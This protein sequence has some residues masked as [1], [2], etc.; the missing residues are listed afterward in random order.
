MGANGTKGKTWS[1]LH[2][3]QTRERNLKAYQT[4]VCMSGKRWKKKAME[5]YQHRWEGDSW[6]AGNH[7]EWQLSSIST[8]DLASEPAGLCCG[9]VQGV[10]GRCG[11][12]PEAAAGSPGACKPATLQGRRTK[13]RH[14]NAPLDSVTLNWMQTILLFRGNLTEEKGVPA[15]A[16]KTFIYLW[17]MFL[18]RFNPF[19]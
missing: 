15:V 1:I 6:L 10:G 7:A 8:P 17:C 14:Q 4:T 13:R 11:S 16:L 12:A 9:Q 5:E 3:V 19:K 2:W 18:T